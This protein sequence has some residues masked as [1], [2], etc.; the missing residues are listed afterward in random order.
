MYY[1]VIALHVI[2]CLV[3]I[4]VI[5]LQSG[6]GGGLAEMFGGAQQQKLFGTQTSTFLSRAT[7]YC[8]VMFIV[9]SISLGFLTS[10]RSRSLLEGAEIKPFFDREPI[11]VNLDE[12]AQTEAEAGAGEAAADLSGIVPEGADAL[13]EAARE[14]GAAADGAADQAAAAAQAG[15]TA[16]VRMTA[17][18][19]GPTE[20]TE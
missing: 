12:G 9:T 17:D 7:T 3:L 10:R 13:G 15:V 2:A 8:A 19:V 5:L 1:V 4:S 14:A 11:S 18:A 6:R 16:A 20:Q